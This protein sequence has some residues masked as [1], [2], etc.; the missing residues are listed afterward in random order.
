M[1]RVVKRVGDCWFD[2]GSEVRWYLRRKLRLL[3]ELI[4]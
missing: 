1:V 2:E 4:F 3:R